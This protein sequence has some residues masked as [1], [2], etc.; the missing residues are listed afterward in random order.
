[1]NGLAGKIALVTGASRGIGR[2]IAQRLA[3]HGAIVAV[4][5][6]AAAVEANALVDGIITAGGSAFAVKA[7]LSD[8]SGAA[9]LAE[10]FTAALAERYGSPV[11]DILVNNAGISKRAAIEDI[12]E[13]DFDRMLQVNLKSPFFLIKSLLP[14]LRE[15]GRI[16]NI[17][18]M[19]TRAAYPTMAA[20]AP[21][22]AGLEA[23]TRLLAVHLGR[24]SITV[25]SVM[26]GATATDMNAPARDP[27]A[28][29][30]V[31]DT[32]ALGRVG[33]P[34]DIAKVVAF[35]ASDEGAWV[36]GQQI[37]AS[38]GQRL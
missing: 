15:S 5:Y 4:H 3:S 33:R 9:I 16:V 13:D 12:T 23:L 6:N 28:S 38:G 34:E 26:P 8:R 14:H 24:R 1:M 36:T 17:S 25:N 21:A 37:D 19:G 2:A 11:F 10:S 30:V 7:D 27:V 35:L 22:K 31:A 29:R 20:Y 18:S 32:I